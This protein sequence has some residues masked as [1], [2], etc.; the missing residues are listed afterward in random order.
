MGTYIISCPL[1]IPL[2]CMAG[3]L[4]SVETISF[5][6]IFMRGW[7]FNLNFHLWPNIIYTYICIDL[8]IIEK[9]AY[10]VTFNLQAEIENLSIEEKRIDEQIRYCNYFYSF[11]LLFVTVLFPP[12]CFYHAKASMMWQRNARKIERPERRRK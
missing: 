7:D 6:G 10:A 9:L 1:A 4:F 8:A 11:C 2:I 5:H 12:F 3:G